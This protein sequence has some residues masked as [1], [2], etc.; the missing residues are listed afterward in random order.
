MLCIRGGSPKPVPVPPIYPMA[1]DIGLYGQFNE[2]P[3]ES[4]SSDYDSDYHD[5]RGKRDRKRANR[6]G[7]LIPTRS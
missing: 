2:P 7:K 4:A 5:N 6:N 3:Y 1:D